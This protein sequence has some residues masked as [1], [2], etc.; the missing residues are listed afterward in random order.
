MFVLCYCISF[1]HFNVFVENFTSYVT[2]YLYVCRCHGLRF[3]DLNTE[4]T[5]LLTYYAYW[6]FVLL[7]CLTLAVL[8][9]LGIFSRLTASCFAVVRPAGRCPLPPILCG[10]I[11]LYLVEV[12]TI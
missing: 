10:A 5:Y 6:Y 11:S 8:L 1:H 4:T 12:S 9:F 3:P 7:G 2:L